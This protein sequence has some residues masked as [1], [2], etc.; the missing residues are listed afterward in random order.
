MRRAVSRFLGPDASTFDNLHSPNNG[1]VTERQRIRA[2]TSAAQQRYQCRMQLGLCSEHAS[3]GVR[4]RERFDG[5]HRQGP[6]LAA[7]DL[8]REPVVA[9]A[10]LQTLRLPF[11]ALGV[12]EGPL[13]LRGLRHNQNVHRR[14]HRARSVA[15]TPPPSEAQTSPRAAPLVR[16]VRRAPPRDRTLIPRNPRSPAAHRTFV[17]RRPPSPAVDQPFVLRRPPAPAAH[18]TFDP[19]LPVSDAAPRAPVRASDST[20]PLVLRVDATR[21]YGARCDP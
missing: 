20:R 16:A 12:E 15:R 19:P 11:E 18:R 8:R 2:C 21:V 1:Y 5:H 14:C 4:K 17:R 7:L 13:D 9:A 10:V 6:R 3:S